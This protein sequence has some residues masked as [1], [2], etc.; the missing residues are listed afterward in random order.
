MAPGPLIPGRLTGP[1]VVSQFIFVGQTWAAIFHSNSMMG[2][3]VA[4]PPAPLAAP[5]SVSEHF[6]QAAHLFAV[7]WWFLMLS[8]TVAGG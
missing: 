6:A 5:P 3:S 8:P 7:L 1:P 4:A 2:G